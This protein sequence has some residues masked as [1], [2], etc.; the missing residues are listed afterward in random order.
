VSKAGLRESGEIPVGFADTDAV[1]S[2]GATLPFRRVLGEALF[3][4]PCA[5]RGKP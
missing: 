3:P 1:T 4:Y 2:T 5:Y